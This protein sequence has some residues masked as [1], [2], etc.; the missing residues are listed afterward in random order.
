MS[1]VAGNAARNAFNAQLASV[2][3]SLLAAAVCEISRIFEGSL[4]DSRAEAERSR[5]EVALLNRKLEALEGRLKEAGEGVTFDPSGFA[6]APDAG[7]PLLLPDLL[8]HEGD[9]S[10]RDGCGDCDPSHRDGCGQARGV[11]EDQDLEVTEL[12]SVIFSQDRAVVSMAIKEEL[13]EQDPEL[14]SVELTGPEGNS[15]GAPEMVGLKEEGAVQRTGPKP[16]QNP[17]LLLDL[18]T[19]RPKLVPG[20]PSFPSDGFSSRGP[21]GG[22]GGP[23]DPLRSFG[24]KPGQAPAAVAEGS[25]L[26]SVPEAV[27]DVTVTASYRRCHPRFDPRRGSQVTVPTGWP[28]SEKVGLV[29]QRPGPDSQYRAEGRAAGAGAGSRHLPVQGPPGEKPYPCPSCSKAFISP[30]HLN[31]HMRVHTG[32]RPYCCPQCGKSFAHNG[33]LRAHQ[34]QVHLGKRPYPC[35]EC[36]KRFSKRG[37]LRTHLQQVHLGRRPYPCPHCRKAYFS[38]RDLRIHQIVHAAQ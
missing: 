25:G 29:N 9:P 17:E 19:A 34:R 24:T 37:N 28:D 14:L 32:E 22:S 35:A 33:N 31:V 15:P 2:M 30:S 4:S 5:E 7:V 1:D 10:H 12:E 6:L 16:L 18:L 3:E 38:L 36:G 8:P 11:K 21:P 27:G 23:G 26:S 13:L 20:Q